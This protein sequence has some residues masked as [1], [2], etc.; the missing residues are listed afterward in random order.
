MARLEQYRRFAQECLQMARTADDAR[1]RAVLI[2]MAQVWFRLA[3]N[4]P[5][6]AGENRPDKS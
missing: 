2:Q 1:V 6:D 4:N 5:H 3:A